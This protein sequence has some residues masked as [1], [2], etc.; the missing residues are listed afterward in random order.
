MSAVSY[1]NSSGLRSLVSGWRQLGSQGG[2]LVLCGLET[3]IQQVFNTVGFDKIF[4]VFATKMEAV[5]H[6]NDA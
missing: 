4:A 5:N 1:I 6:L 2:T 3:R